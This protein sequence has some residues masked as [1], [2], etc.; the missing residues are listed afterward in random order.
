MKRLAQGL[1]IAGCLALIG[2]G[3]GFLGFLRVA[4]AVPEAAERRSAGIVVLTGG[5]DRVATGLRLLREGRGERMLISG[6][7]PDTRLEDLASGAEPGGLA[8][9]VELGR[10]ARS[11]RGNAREVAAWARAHRLDSIRVVTAGYHM[12]RAML[13]LRRTLPEVE[14][15]PWQVTPPQLRQ[16]GALAEARTWSLLVGEYL[17]LLL[18]WTGLPAVLMK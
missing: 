1:L 16:A 5:A 8:T 17:K 7:H 2:L 6:V 10:H 15:L 9:Q 18:A 12:P 4:G 14:L 13:E 11:T 3:L